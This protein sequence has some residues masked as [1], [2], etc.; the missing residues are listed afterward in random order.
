VNDR[1]ALVVTGGRELSG[2]VDLPGTKHGTVLA[3]AAAVATGSRLR[4]LDAPALTDRWVLAEIVARLGGAATGTGTVVD[5]DG[6]VEG[7]EIPRDLARLVHGSLYL[8]PAVL[9]NRGSVVFHAAGGDGFGSFDRGMS[10]PVQHM[11]DV[12][13]AFG[14]TSRWHEDGTLRVDLARPRPANLNLLDWS[15]DPVL[16]EGPHVSGASKTALLMA[17]ATP[18]TSTILHPHAR[19]AQHELISLLRALGVHIEQRDACWLV[20]GGP[21]GASAEHRLMP[22][23]VE[24]ATWQAIAAVTGSW[25]EAR[26]ADTSRLFAAVHRELAFLAGLGIEPVVEPT[27]V[28]MG[29]AGGPYPGRGLVAESTG[30]STDITPLLALVLNGATGPSTVADRIWTDR[31]DYAA[32]LNRLGADMTVRDHELH[33]TPRP[34]RPGTEALTPADTRSAAVCVAAALSVPATTV[35]HG[36]RHLE[37]GYGGFVDRLRA[38][39]ADVSVAGESRAAG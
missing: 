7:T 35:V 3:F 10:R 19:E 38:L 18:G 9:A 5:V 4:L 32:Q 8:L 30:I 21:G 36:L 13:A 37:R 27:A 14:A 2:V 16:P 11:L 31:F 15:T 22:C 26:S 33:I 17:A 39:G 34:L 24:F 12:M 6:R 29:P 23:P 28:R 20:T 25:I 1:D